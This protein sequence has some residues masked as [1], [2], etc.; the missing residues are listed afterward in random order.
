MRQSISLWLAALAVAAGCGGK[1]QPLGDAKTDAN[2]GE[3]GSA[4]AGTNT[5]GTAVSSGGA[6]NT[7][8]PVVPRGGSHVMEPIP[9]AGTSGDAGKTSSTTDPYSQEPCYSICAEEIFRDPVGCKLCHSPTFAASGLDL[10]SLG[11]A[12]R[13]KDVAAKHADL[14]GGQGGCPQGDKLIDSANVEDSWMLKKLRGEQGSC[15]AKDPPQAAL[16]PADLACL[17]MYIGCVA[18]Q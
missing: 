7:D 4:A 3:S 13:L 8:D 12:A 9:A 11:R 5:A 18:T 6:A 2:D 15:G 10:D 14:E 17:T 16:A 1:W